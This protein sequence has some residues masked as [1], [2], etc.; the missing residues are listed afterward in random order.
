MQEAAKG[1]VVILIHL[2]KSQKVQGTSMGHDNVNIGSRMILGEVI[3]W[4]DLKICAQCFL[5]SL[6]DAE[7][8]RESE[9]H[10]LEG[11]SNYFRCNSEPR[12]CYSGIILCYWQTSV[13]DGAESSKDDFRWDIYKIQAPLLK[14]FLTFCSRQRRRN[15]VDRETTSHLEMIICGTILHHGISRR[16]IYLP[17]PHIVVH[18]I[19]HCKDQ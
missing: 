1:G 14:V 5:A 16:A 7:C 4:S 10:Q 19:T 11:Y 3:I 17:P 6:C 18:A 13:W 15:H 8:M 12:S 2:E 9:T